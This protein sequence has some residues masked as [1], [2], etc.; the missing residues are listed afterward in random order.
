MAVNVKNL[1]LA[2]KR[3]PRTARDRILALNKGKAYTL[4]E[5][6]SEWGLSLKTIR[7]HA[8]DLDCFRW[9]ELENGAWEEVV[10]HPE[11]AKGVK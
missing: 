1:T 6:H 11:T 9:M 8:K 10:L 3:P 7:A 5:L 2:R 4:A